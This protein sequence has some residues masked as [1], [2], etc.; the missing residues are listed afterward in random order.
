M[1][2]RFSPAPVDLFSRSRLQSTHGARLCTT[3]QVWV[4]G[5]LRGACSGRSKSRNLASNHGVALRGPE[6]SKTMENPHVGHCCIAQQHG[7]NNRFKLSSV[8]QLQ[9][10]LQY[11]CVDHC[12]TC[13][14]MMYACMRCVCAPCTCARVYGSVHGACQ[15][16]VVAYWEG[17]IQS[18]CCK[19]IFH[20]HMYLNGA[21]ISAHWQ[22]GPV[23]AELSSLAFISLNSK[24]CWDTAAVAPPPARVWI[25]NSSTNS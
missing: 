6:P 10:R 5:R 20:L 13:V 1:F 25:R 8:L 15:H 7:N 18:M 19:H 16:S 24:P 22:A 12:Y 3:A 23:C 4:Q 17:H 14:V 2:A 11:A 9:T 21:Y